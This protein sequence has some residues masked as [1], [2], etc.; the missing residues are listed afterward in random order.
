[1][2][3]LGEEAF[4]SQMKVVATFL[5]LL[6]ELM[7]NKQQDLR[8]GTKT[9]RRG[10]LGR[11]KDFVGGIFKKVY[12][13][14]FGRLSRNGKDY[15]Q[16]D[17]NDPAVAKLFA[18]TMKQMGMDAMHEDNN[19]L[20][21]T[22]DVAKILAFSKMVEQE[23][24]KKI[25][26]ENDTPE[27]EQSQE[28]GQDQERQADARGWSDYPAT[29]EQID[30]TA[31]VLAADE[32]VSIDEIKKDFS[33]NPSIG[34]LQI[35]L[36]A[37]GHDTMAIQPDLKNYAT[38]EQRAQLDMLKDKGIIGENELMQL[39]KYPSQDKA[40]EVLEN[41][42]DAVK[43]LDSD[44]ISNRAEAIR[45]HDGMDPDSHTNIKSSLDDLR[46]KGHHIGAWVRYGY[47]KD[48]NQKGHIIPDPVAA[49]VV[50]RIFKMYLEGNSR[51]DIARILNSEQIPPPGLYK[52]QQGDKYKNA[53]MAGEWDSCSISRILK[54]EMYIGNMVQGRQASESY[55]TKKLRTLPKEDWIRVIGTHEAIISLET[56]NQTQ[57][58]LAVGARSF[59]R[60]EEI[61]LFSRKVYC[62]HCN[63]LMRTG[64]S[65]R[66][67]GTYYNYVICVRRHPEIN[68]CP[69]HAVSNAL[70]E[71]TILDQLDIL[72]AKYK[73]GSLF[74]EIMDEESTI[75]IEIKRLKAELAQHKKK[76][77]E[78]ESGL[79]CLYLDKAS[80]SISN[81]DYQFLSRELSAGKELAERKVDL[82]TENYNKILRSQEILREKA[83]VLE[84]Y[85]RPK[86]LTRSMVETFIDHIVICSSSDGTSKQEIK[87]YWNF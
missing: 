23:L 80:G 5:R 53:F 16:L 43:M 75:G 42:A 17:L 37:K 26:H 20:F 1:M 12:D 57:A 87:I 81:S 31:T 86:E 59:T 66:K 7:R 62:G 11:M 22:S 3:D 60:S 71:K 18:D 77:V 70:M 85:S 84:S 4:S 41:H 51:A 58:L 48:P 76:L 72:A 27:K 45:S 64:R 21:S 44:E 74:S 52:I 47:M 54:E 56:W 15:G 29:P 14:T 8:Y 13:G 68:P 49:A 50:E 82:C 65:K 40:S 79:K 83:G 25:E 6:E 55:K 39:G 10:I 24:G 61:G 30:L 63:K 35:A 2:A 32:G 46:R 67:S 9:Q 69:V 38:P 19:L 34:E 36:E 78:Y 28:H 33:E 73:D